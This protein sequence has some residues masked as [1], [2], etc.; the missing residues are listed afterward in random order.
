MHW[1]LLLKMEG[2][3]GIEPPPRFSDE[4]VGF[5]DR[6]VPSTIAPANPGSETRQNFKAQPQQSL[7][8]PQLLHPQPKERADEILKPFLEKSI[9]MG[10]AWAKKALSIKY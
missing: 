2:A 5:E 10:C 7:V 9:S 4:A 6:G 3:R 1:S 8:D